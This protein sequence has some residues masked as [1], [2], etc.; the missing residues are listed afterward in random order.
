[1]HMLPLPMDLAVFRSLGAEGSNFCVNVLAMMVIQLFFCLLS[2]RVRE[3]VGSNGQGKSK[4]RTGKLYGHPHALSKVDIDY[5]STFPA[6]L[7]EVALLAAPLPKYPQLSPHWHGAGQWCALKPVL[8]CAIRKIVV[9]KR[10]WFYMK[11]FHQGYLIFLWCWEKQLN[12]TRELVGGIYY[13][14]KSI[15][16]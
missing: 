16:R 15:L 7:S 8:Q 2:S 6:P 14:Q 1:M 12:Q 9:A 3:V 10:F 13:V 11:L 4:S 5:P